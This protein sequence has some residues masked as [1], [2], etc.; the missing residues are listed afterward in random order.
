MP[1]MSLSVYLDRLGR[2]VDQ[3]FGGEDRMRSVARTTYGDG[4]GWPA[5]DILE[6]EESL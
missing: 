6:W 3:A 1:N 4:I 2:G 5:A